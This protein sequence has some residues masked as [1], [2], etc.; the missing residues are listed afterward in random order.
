MSAFTGA[1]GSVI[2]YLG[3]E[4]ASESLFER[5]LWPER[6]YNDANIYTLVKLAVFLPMA[7]PL[8]AAALETLD[9][10][11]ENGLYQ[12]MCR[13]NMLGTTFYRDTGLM[14]YR[15]IDA[16]NREDGKACRNAFWVQVLREAKCPNTK[17]RLTQA[18]PADPT[19]DIT[20]PY[21]AMQ[22]V[23]NL[24]LRYASD[25]AHAG[26]GVI[27]ITETHAT[28]R[29]AIGILLSE[30]SSL[31]VAIV[32]GTAKPLQNGWLAGY[33]LVPVALKV[34]SLFTSVRRE[35]IQDNKDKTQDL[36]R[37]KDHL[38]EIEDPTHSYAI[39]QGPE[40]V[41]KQFF[42]HYGHP[43]RDSGTAGR[44]DR[45]RELLSMALVYAFVLYFPIGLVV[46][47]W[48][49][50]NVQIVWLSF[51]MY[52]ILA[53]HVAR[54]LGW[55]TCGRTEARVARELQKGRCVWLRN[56]GKGAGIVASLET[57][58]HRSVNQARVE[59][60][61]IIDEHFNPPRPTAQP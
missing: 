15:I 59:M 47:L 14:C 21:R 58:D 13:G 18:D 3:A 60:N 28:W 40:S 52:T 32:V 42:R 39:I 19:G 1:L 25:A 41:V 44:T 54:I 8:H 35:A 7:G 36:P 34:L 48:M 56:S 38:Y 6:F 51:Q 29:T 17:A 11:R 30:L 9:S 22:L 33:L 53:T 37:S 16:K 23:H 50:Q 4:A 49:P 57:T 10:F 5:V 20:T 27:S 46:V 31:G 61:S 43:V 55:N 12:G 26:A 24:K 45:V 2:G